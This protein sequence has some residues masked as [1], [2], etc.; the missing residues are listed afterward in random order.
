MNLIPPTPGKVLR[1]LTIGILLLGIWIYRQPL[2]SALSLFGSPQAVIEFLQ[3]HE[4]NGLLMLSLLMLAQVFLA[5]IP[6]QALMAASGYLYGAPI[7]LAVV[8]S[9]TII[10]SEIAFWLARIYG[11]P[12]IY[13]LASSQ[14]IDY[15]DRTAGHLGPMFYLLAFMLPVFPADLMCY[16][17]GLGKVSPRGFFFANVVGRSVT[18]VTFTLLGAYGFRPPMWF[19]ILAAFSL[20][21]ILLS[22]RNYK[23][24]HMQPQASDAE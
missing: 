2:W 20:V 9:T 16:V 24:K 15:W 19:W 7:T 14:V 22:W 6:G 4:S 1:F 8:A 18:A 5:L 13:K 17:A 3:R 10:G 11:R 12:L 21:V 23:K